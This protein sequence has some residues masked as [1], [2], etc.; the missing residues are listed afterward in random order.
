[1]VVRLADEP[2][3]SDRLASEPTSRCPSESTVSAGHWCSR[4][5]RAA[6]GFA[7]RKNK[8]PR[9]SQPRTQKL[10]HGKPYPTGFDRSFR[11]VCFLGLASV[12]LYSSVS[13]NT[14]DAAARRRDQDRTER[15]PNLRHAAHRYPDQ[16]QSTPCRF[17][18]QT[19]FRR[20][21]AT[22]GSRLV[23]WHSDYDW[24]ILSQSRMGKFSGATRIW[25]LR[26]TPG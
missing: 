9:Q 16:V 23:P 6:T 22:G 7:D 18:S 3:C 21:R 20:N 24:L 14:P 26:A 10:Y 5:T 17:I 8:R 2:L 25:M 13:R 15:H 4:S 11:F 12:P 1:V 19:L